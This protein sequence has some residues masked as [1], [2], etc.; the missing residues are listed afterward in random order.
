M[1]PWPY[2]VTLVALA[3]IGQPVRSAS[4][5]GGSMDVIQLD[6]QHTNVKF[7]LLGNLHDTDGRFALKRGTIAIDVNNGN[8]GGQI[9]ID[10]TSEDSREHLRDAIMRNAILDARHYPEIVFIPQ[11]VEGDR[12]LQ[13]NLYGRIKG[14]MQL[15]G[16]MHEIGTEFQGH[17]SGD[18]L[19][20]QC[21]FL[22]PYVQWGL[23]S[24]NVLT[25]RQIVDST[26]GDDNF[27][28]RSFQVFAYM[29]PVLRKIPPN[30]FQVSDLVEVTVE[31][32]AHVRWAPQAQA[33]MVNVIVS[34][35]ARATGM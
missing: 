31:A 21:T 32:T 4:I 6:P 14:L 3:F 24:P 13:G 10:A 9:V 27:G 26:A 15:H 25:P 2:V 18:E 33:R 28:T 8:A 29:L 5:L 34:P 22:V 19:I 11:R 35:P 30:L 1:R 17:L 7:V 20:A 23:E 16:S 12:D